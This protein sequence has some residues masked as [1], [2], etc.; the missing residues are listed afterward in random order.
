MERGPRETTT[1][2]D[3]YA[4]RVLEEVGH[5]TDVVHA[6]D[7]LDMCSYKFKYRVFFLLVH[8]KK[9]SDYI[10]NPIKK[11]SGTLRVIFRADH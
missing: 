7:I 2:V 3:K 11:S 4:E 6:M 5:A 1:A 8:P 9:M 10:V